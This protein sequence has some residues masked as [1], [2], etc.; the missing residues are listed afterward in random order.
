MMPSEL[1]GGMAR[2]VALARSIAL[3]P[4]IM[5]YDEPFTGQDPTSFNT[6]L[7]LIKTL[8]T[9]LGMT[10]LLVS[11]DIE[12]AMNISDNII[13]VANKTVIANDT[14][15]NIRKSDNQ[16]IK[17][18]INGNYYETKNEQSNTNSDFFRK[19]LLN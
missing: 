12:E 3:D 19:E 5:M 6:I 7:T 18:F 11:H 2:R 1:S 10:S 9:T 16:T 4:E 15:E 14:P 13:I 17:D 8:N